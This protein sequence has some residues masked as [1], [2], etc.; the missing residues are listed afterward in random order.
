[1]PDKVSKCGVGL[2]VCQISYAK[3]SKQIRMECVKEKK[4][5]LTGV[6]FN[7]AYRYMDWLLAMPVDLSDLTACMP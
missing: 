1:M 3:S 6:P 4:P 5:E 2:A 7:D